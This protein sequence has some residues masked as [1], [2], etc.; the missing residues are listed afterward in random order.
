MEP[1]ALGLTCKDAM[2]VFSQNETLVLQRRISELENRLARHEPVVQ[3]MHTFPDI[4]SY[5]DECDRACEYI[6]SWID[7]N[8]KSCRGIDYDMMQIH[9]ICDI[10]R[11]KDAIEVMVNRMTAHDLLSRTVA[12]LALKV[13]CAACRAAFSVGRHEWCSNEGRVRDVVFEA[14]DEFVFDYLT[15]DIKATTYPDIDDINDLNELF[16]AEDAMIV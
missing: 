9:A 11:L 3:G 4:K 5:C 8:V 6:S 15:Q 10:Y 2:V 14:I 7:E 13:V 1:A 16:D 12:S